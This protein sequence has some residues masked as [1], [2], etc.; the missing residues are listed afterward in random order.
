MNEI[1]YCMLILYLK[2]QEGREM[3]KKLMIMK[4]NF[5]TNAPY[6]QL[7]PVLHQGGFV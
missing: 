7:D 3:G 4:G 1:H 2:V 6:G 5:S